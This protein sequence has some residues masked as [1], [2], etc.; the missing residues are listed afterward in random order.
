MQVRKGELARGLGSILALLAVAWLSGCGT[1]DG[2]SMDETAVSWSI[3]VASLDGG[4][5]GASILLNGELLYSE[6]GTGRSSHAV[7]VVRPY[8]AGENVIEVE[9]LASTIAAGAYVASCTGEV[10]PTGQVVHADGVPQSLEVGERLFLR[11]SL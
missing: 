3:G 7:E 2:P 9:I 5:F 10:T 4:E 11:L 6:P 8:Q 1:A